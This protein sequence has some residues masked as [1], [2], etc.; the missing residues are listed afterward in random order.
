MGSGGRHRSPAA[1]AQ[2]AALSCR[3]GA[4]QPV[5]LKRLV[6]LC[7]LLEQLGRISCWFEPESVDKEA[8]EGQPDCTTFMR[9]RKL[10]S[11]PRAALLMDMVSA[12][13]TFMN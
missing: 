2:K 8:E 4:V 10:P 5:V 12:S 13:P 7:G 3:G 11:C 9:P 6:P 1:V